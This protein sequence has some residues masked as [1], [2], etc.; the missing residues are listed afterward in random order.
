[1]E[2]LMIDNYDSFT[3]NLMRYFLELGTSVTVWRNDQFD[4]EEVRTFNPDALIISP[5]PSHPQNSGRSLEVI[6][7]FHTSVPILGV[8][9]G[10]QCIAEAFGGTVV[11]SGEPVHGK[12]SPI[13]H[14]HSGVFEHLPS[15]LRVTRYHSL[16]VQD[17]PDTLLGNAWSADGTLMGLQHQQYP[18]HGVQFHPESALTEKG[19]QLLDNFLKIARAFK[20]HN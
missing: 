8:C 13:T 16:I 5:G 17:L 7:Q 20:G 2:L 10:H 4:L 18:V 15:P 6:Q 3:F 9:L 12:T 14:D 19:H 11:K 1:M